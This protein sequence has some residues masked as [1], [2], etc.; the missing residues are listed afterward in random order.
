MAAGVVPAPFV[1]TD[2]DK[3]GLIVVSVSISL[4]FVWVCLLVRTWLR[5]Q[6]REWRSDDF[7]LAAATVCLMPALRLHTPN[8]TT[9]A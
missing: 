2:N 3:R 8:T 6:T 4:A 1:I 5:C 9:V 7:F